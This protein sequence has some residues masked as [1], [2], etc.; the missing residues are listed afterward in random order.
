M[1]EMV[2][3]TITYS[4]IDLPLRTACVRIYISDTARLFVTTKSKM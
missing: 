2:F 3:G 1:T 4:F